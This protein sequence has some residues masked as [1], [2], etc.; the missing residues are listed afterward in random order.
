MEEGISIDYKSL[1]KVVD[2][3]GKLRSEGLRKELNI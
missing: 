3:S 2:S 1:K